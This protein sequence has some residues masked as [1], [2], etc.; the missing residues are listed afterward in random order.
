MGST[1]QPQVEAEINDVEYRANL[2]WTIPDFM[3]WT[4][5]S[6]LDSLKYRAV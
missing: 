3:R 6:Q 1:N 4:Q 2:I 5:S